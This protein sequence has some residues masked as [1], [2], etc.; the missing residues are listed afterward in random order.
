[1]PPAKKPKQN[2]FSTLIDR[3]WDKSLVVGL[4][5]YGQGDTQ[6]LQIEVFDDEGKLVECEK[7][8]KKETTETASKRLIKRMEKEGSL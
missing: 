8:R 7:V 1:V 4:E 6:G 5:L 2:P 3:A